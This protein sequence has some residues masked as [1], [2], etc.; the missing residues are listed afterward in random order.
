MKAVEWVDYV[1]GKL[2]KSKTECA[3]RI[4]H[5]EVESLADSSERLDG[6]LAVVRM[7][8]KH[9]VQASPAMSQ[10]FS[11]VKASILKRQEA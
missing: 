2:E 4:I 3:E 1:D 9:D 5:D 8:Q 6:L 11:L 10:A 7:M